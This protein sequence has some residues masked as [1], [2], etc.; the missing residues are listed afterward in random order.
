LDK[1][2]VTSGREKT[3]ASNPKTRKKRIV[4]SIK[5]KSYGG[6]EQSKDLINKAILFDF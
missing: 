2:A 6:E 1:R 4:F 5:R 3:V